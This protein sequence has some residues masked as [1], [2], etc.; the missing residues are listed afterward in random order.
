MNW[1]Q[2]EI[3]KLKILRQEG[4]SFKDIASKL[5][6]SIGSV[7][8]QY[9]RDNNK[10]GKIIDKNMYTKEDVLKNRMRLLKGY[11]KDFNKYR[12]DFL[13]NGGD[14]RFKKASIYLIFFPNTS[15]MKVGVSINV[16]RRQSTFGLNNTILSYVSIPV[17][18][19]I[20]EFVEGYILNK[21]KNYITYSNTLK[22][23]KTE[24]F[25][26]NI[27]NIDN[28]VREVDIVIKAITNSFN[29]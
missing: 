17:D 26:Y 16:E 24:L 12:I 28:L 11:N 18:R 13:K 9:T 6:R 3:K 19:Y 25:K 20:A 2:D 10:K 27:D 15:E 29:T 14:R 1:T 4:N 23:G 21:F 7:R 8:G 22:D 5:N